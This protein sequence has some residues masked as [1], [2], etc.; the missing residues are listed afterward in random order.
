MMSEIL[1]IMFTVIVPC[2]HI[3]HFITPRPGPG[4]VISS[5]Y[6][7]YEYDFG[8]MLPESVM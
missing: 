7:G 2:S 3:V 6:P 4:E 8:L 5:S 1:F